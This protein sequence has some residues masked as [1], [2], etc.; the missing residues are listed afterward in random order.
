MK[1]SRFTAFPALFVSLAL[2][3]EVSAQVGS[4]EFVY[5][6]GDPNPLTGEGVSLGGFVFPNLYFFGTGGVFEPGSNAEDFANSEHDPQNEIGVQAIELDIDFLFSDTLTGRVTGNGF[7]VANHVWEAELE[8]AFLD[9]AV[10]DWLTLRGGQFLNTIGFQSHRHIHDWDFVNQNLTNSRFINEGHLISQG[11][12]FVIDTPGVGVLN[13]A[14]GGVRRHSHEEEHEEEY[15]VE[16]H[17]AEFDDFVFSVDHRFSLPHDDSITLASFLAGGGNGIYGDTYVFGVG[18]RKV[19]NGHNHGR[20]PEFCTGALM[21]QS[22]FM[23][24]SV[25]G[26]NEDGERFDFEDFGFST[27]LLYGLTDA[28]TLS[29]RHDFV[30]EVENSE[31]HPTHRVSPAVSIFVDPQQRV[32]ARFQYDY[33]DNRELGGEHVGWFQVQVTWGGEGGS[34]AGHNH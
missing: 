21:L 30:S 5:H 7:Q 10:T 13:A 3:F 6:V 33:I 9:V 29:L 1:V 16:A 34:H 32:R 2:S 25:D 14:I 26:L 22:E 8:E 31:L 19:W 4:D 18:A 27:T 24:R 28:V 11:G 23:K 17:G 15:P 20:G 12:Q